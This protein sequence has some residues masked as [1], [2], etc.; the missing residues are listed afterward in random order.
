MNP[1][2]R[3]KRRGKTRPKRLTSVRP[4]LFRGNARIRSRIGRNTFNPR[5]ERAKAPAWALPKE[6][7]PTSFP[8]PQQH[9][10]AL[11][12]LVPP[13]DEFPASVPR[14]SQPVTLR[15]CHSSVSGDRHPEGRARRGLCALRAGRLFSDGLDGWLRAGQAIHELASISTHRDSCC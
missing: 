5:F 3:S 7:P 4:A 11:D 8:A 10:N 12:G 2:R 9:Q 14:R 1:S 13:S 6:I 15:V